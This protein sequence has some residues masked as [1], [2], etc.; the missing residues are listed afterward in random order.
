MRKKTENDRFPIVKRG[1]EPEAVE[2][3]LEEIAAQT[4]ET[5]DEAAQQIV[6]LQG[7][8]EELQRN[9]E[10]VQLTI[11]AATET[12][13]KMLTVAQQQA[14]TLRDEGRKAG[15]A[16][17]TEARMQAFQ[18]VTE[19]RTEAEGVV[20]EAMAETAA[21]S[22]DRDATPAPV[23]ASS[24]REEELEAQVARMQS[25]IADMESQLLSRVAPEESRAAEPEPDEASASV[26]DEDESDDT[27]PV[28]EVEPLDDEIDESDQATTE[29]VAEERIE[30]VM[31][32]PAPV[33][34][35]ISDNADFS[36]ELPIGPELPG[37]QAIRRSFY[38]RR[39][40]KLPRIGVE[41]G[42]GAMAAVAGLRTNGVAEESTNG[43]DEDMTEEAPK[44]ETV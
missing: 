35:E 28:S 34:P 15:D 13:E 31:T 32:D 16:I 11:L 42:R 6:S 2:R 33:A 30:I 22:R 5:L 26:V 18:V 40:A 41:A 14:D 24:D 27:P 23:T 21:M 1:Y 43:A 36:D 29:A 4:D 37:A 3:H 17:I 38:S 19:A 9:E 12:K 8:I 39:S 10:A 20:A 44:F 25:V 7:E